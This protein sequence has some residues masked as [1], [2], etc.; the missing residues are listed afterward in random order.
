MRKRLLVDFL[1]IF[2][3]ASIACAGCYQRYSPRVTPTQQAMNKL[4]EHNRQFDILKQ[5]WEK[6]KQQKKD[7]ETRLDSLLQQQTA[8][9]ETLDTDEQKKLYS[10]FW[11][12]IMPSNDQIKIYEFIEKMR[13]T[14]PADKIET[15][16]DL[17][18]EEK[19]LESESVEL[20]KQYELIMLRSQELKRQ[21]EEIEMRRQ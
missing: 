13:A 5:N 20:S 19:K 21:L 18:R 15:F 11:E 9:G 1:L 4:S 10:D 3:I 17:Y 12:F 8:F 16:M 7:F 6:H 14:L 2:L